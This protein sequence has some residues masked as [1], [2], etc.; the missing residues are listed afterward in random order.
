[1]LDASYP[2]P[3]VPFLRLLLVYITSPKHLLLAKV[4]TNCIHSEIMAR[5]PERGT[6]KGAEWGAVLLEG[7]GEGALP[8]DFIP[9]P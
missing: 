6:W 7:D 8:W 9:W 5:Q 4:I 3:V 2:I 1:L